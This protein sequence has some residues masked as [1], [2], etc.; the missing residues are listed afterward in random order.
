[1]KYKEIKLEPTPFSVKV[2]YSKDPKEFAPKFKKLYK[3]GD[4]D[5][6]FRDAFKN[7]YAFVSSVNS[8]KGT[9]I[10]VCFNTLRPDIVVHECVHITW[11]LQ[12]F[13]HMEFNYE[14]QEAQAYY[15]QHLY[16]EILKLK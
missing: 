8:K 5:N 7:Y 3:D 14:S 12:K 1:M 4:W 6:Y 11:F 15:V 2:F 16:K 13:T 9:D 10:I